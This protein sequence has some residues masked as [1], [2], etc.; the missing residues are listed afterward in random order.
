MIVVGDASVF[1]ALERGGALELLP[2]L[3]YE[4]HVPEAVW[5]EIFSS[6][7]KPPDARWRPAWG[8]R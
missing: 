1:I 7:T 6:S 5:R 2:A 3:F 8:W 4:V